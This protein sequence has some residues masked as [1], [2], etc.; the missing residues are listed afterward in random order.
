MYERCRIH[1][2]LPLLALALAVTLSA[3]SEKH[4]SPTEPDF[5]S[6]ST[7]SV[8]S[9]SGEARGGNGGG[10]GNGNGGGRNPRNPPGGG[11][12]TLEIQPDTWNTNWEHSQGT[13]SALIR[14]QRLADVDL[15]S[16]Q[17]VG[18]DDSAAPVPALRTQ[19]A[20]NHIRVFF[21]QS[22]AIESLDSPER[23]EVHEV[24]IELTVDDEETTLTDRVRIVGPAGGGGDD[25]DEEVELT[26]EIQP[27]SWN[28]NWGNSAGTVSALIRGTG[29]DEVDLRSIELEGTDAGAA[30]VEAL[31]AQRAGNHIRAFFDKGDAFDTLDT[32]RPG[33][34]HRITIRLSAGEDDEE[35]ELTDRIRVVGP[36]R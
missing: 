2:Y 26:V 24:T 23:G 22:D 28:M 25:D 35:I 4:R 11:S 30:P 18:S 36:S 17:L 19:R 13:V 9:V 14:G 31:R 15:S 32:P 27:D 8:S 6:A 1:Q 29:L 10:N 5:V 7:S 21:R 12:L 33:E 16:I 20:G 3:C 34:T